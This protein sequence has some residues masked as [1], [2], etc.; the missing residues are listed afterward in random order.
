MK[1][2]KLA[3]GLIGVALAL[4]TIPRMRI[5][6][7]S[8]QGVLL[9]N[10]ILLLFGVLLA[11]LGF[12]VIKTEGITNRIKV[13]IK[14]TSIQVF[15]SK[16]KARKASNILAVFLSL[17][18][19]FYGATYFWAGLA[20]DRTFQAWDFWVMLITGPLFLLIILLALTM[21]RK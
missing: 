17:P 6:F 12:N 15:G 8:S 1:A 14:K 5:S 21:D 2:I 7:L 13:W 4:F 10:S 20:G 19:G 11:L 18:C 9:C 3:V 16:N